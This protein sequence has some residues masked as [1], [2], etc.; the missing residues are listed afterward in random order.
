MHL[1]APS[2]CDLG[3]VSYEEGLAAQHDCWEKRRARETGDTLLLCEHPPVYT[4]GSNATE[5]DVLERRA[6]VVQTDR[7]G[8]VTF[9][10]PGQVVGYV[11]CDIIARG[12]DLHGFCRDLEEIMLRALGDF[13]LE[14]R[15]IDGLTGVWLG[16]AKVGALGVRVRKW[17]TLHGFA[18]N[19]DCD[20]SYFD[21]IVPCGI[22]DKSVTSMARALGRAMDPEPVKESCARHFE[23]IFG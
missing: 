22:A 15:R 19:V 13:G 17:V 4:L 3:R 6:P 9:H 14:G 1:A 5:K 8:Q 7:G 20:L 12:K 23:A 16:D 2:I 11:I 10:G 21:G 18:L